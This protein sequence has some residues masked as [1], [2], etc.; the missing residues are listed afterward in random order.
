MVPNNPLKRRY[1]IKFQKYDS[2]K[3]I[4]KSIKPDFTITKKMYF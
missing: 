3:K 2:K 4:T 1:D